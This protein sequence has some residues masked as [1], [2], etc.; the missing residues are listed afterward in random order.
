MHPPFQLCHLPVD[1]LGWM[2][3]SGNHMVP[4]LN[5]L[6]SQAVGY[7][8]P[9]V[10]Q[11]QSICHIKLI[12]CDNNIEL[13]TGLPGPATLEVFWHCLDLH[14]FSCLFTYLLWFSIRHWQRV[15]MSAWFSTFSVELQWLICSHK[16]LTWRVY[17]LDVIPI[18]FHYEALYPRPSLTRRPT[19]SFP[20]WDLYPQLRRTKGAKIK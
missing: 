15:F 12:W 7:Y 18:N 8:N 5:Y 20:L 19:Y 13:C 1:A 3:H 14:I 9:I 10:S 11:Q 16:V 17:Q 2:W 4:F 6:Q